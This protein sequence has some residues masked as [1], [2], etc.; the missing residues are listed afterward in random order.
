MKVC[1]SAKITLLD[2]AK[3]SQTV[4]SNF[5]KPCN[6]RDLSCSGKISIMPPR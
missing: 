2:Y 3:N 5:N 1:A 4:I 6:E